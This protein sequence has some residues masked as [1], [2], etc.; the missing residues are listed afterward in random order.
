MKSRANGE[1]SMVLGLQC[2]ICEKSYSPEVLYT[3][4]TCGSDG[5]LDVLYKY[6]S[7]P[8]TFRPET[9]ASRPHDI[10]RYEELLP[11][12]GTEQLPPTKIGW[13]PIIEAAQLAALSGVKRLYLKD[14]GRNPTASFKDRASAI[15]VAKA[16]ELGFSDVACASTGNA[17]SSLAGAAAA[18]GLR[19][20]IFVPENAPEPKVMQLLIFGARVVRVKKPSSGI[21]AYEAAYDLCTQAC[22][23]YGWYNRNCAIN[24]YLVEG[25]KTAGLEIAEQMRFDLPDWVVVSVGDGCTIAGVGKGLAEMQRLG[26][27]ERQPRL[28]GVQAEGAAPIAKTFFAGGELAPDRGESLAESIAVSKPRNWRK[29]INAIRDSQGTMITVS[30]EEILQAQSLT[31]RLGGVFGEPAGV[32]GIAGLKKAVAAGVI[33]NSAPVLAVITGSGL[34]DVQVVRRT[35]KMPE[36]IEADMEGLDRYL[37]V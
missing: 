37:K 29:A 24:A 25:K 13:T 35:V 2:V 15:G 33:S 34:K 30:D 3:C 31:A 9:L 4:P 22:E 8:K 11:I 10:R 36:P 1:M 18:V 21:T 20:T 28:L 32:A 16:K 12:R 5:I 27:I 26:W 7:V 6:E 14:E 17:A 19:S 23:R